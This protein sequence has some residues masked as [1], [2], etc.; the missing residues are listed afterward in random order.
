MQTRTKIISAT[1]TAA[2]VLGLAG[3]GTAVALDKTVTLRVGE[4][5]RQVSGFGLTTTVGDVLRANGVTLEG[6]DSVSPAV[7][8]AVANGQTVTVTLRRPVLVSVTRD[9]ITSTT[10][11]YATTV[12]GV[13]TE[14][15]VTYDADDRLSVPAEA[16]LTDRSDVTVRRVAVAEVAE[17]VAVPFAATTVD[18]ATRT[19]GTSSVTTPGAPGVLT[20][21]FAVTTVDG[22][23]ESRTLVSEAVTTQ[24]VAQVTSVGTKAKATAVAPSSAGGT[25]A[26]S[27]SG[28]GLNLANAEMWDR[29][30]QCE[31]SGNWHINTGN[32]YYGGLQFSSSTWL[33]NGGADFASRADLA[34]REQQ[35]T[36]ANR[37]YAKNGL[38]DWTC[39]G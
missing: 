8:T 31:S 35:I 37:L 16:S 12:A 34:S 15:G 28:A 1:L 6:R 7:D 14:L 30:A 10:L 5:T 29:V 32:G 22:V 9:G 25:A 24:P 20:K 4:Q 27:T 38:R 17:T 21:T 19:K 39:K 36:V 26:G 33:A 23:E 11:T 3:T 18:D 2:A 13:L